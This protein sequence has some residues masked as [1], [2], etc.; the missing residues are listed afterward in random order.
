MYE[1][2]MIKSKPIY[3]RDMQFFGLAKKPRP[4]IVGQGSLASNPE[5]VQD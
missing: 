5:G 1:T 2:E 4:M 3:F